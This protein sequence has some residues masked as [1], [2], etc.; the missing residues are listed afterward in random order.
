MQNMELFG[1]PTSPY[2]RRVRITALEFDLPIEMIDTRGPREQEML[3]SLNPLWR[4]PAAR[5]GDEVVFDS[6]AIINRILEDSGN[7]MET[8]PG[9]PYWEASNYLHA[10][11]GA[12]NSAINSFYLKKDGVDP[13]TIDYLAKQDARVGNTMAYLND[14][15]HTEDLACTCPSTAAVAL[16]TTLDWMVFRKAY[17]VSAHSALAQFHSNW[18]ERPSFAATRPPK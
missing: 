8:A 13:K 3:R 9:K 2:V 4:V 12:L 15:L 10:I 6:A 16:F 18:A 5:F 1:T 17:D 11:D 7:H 14:V